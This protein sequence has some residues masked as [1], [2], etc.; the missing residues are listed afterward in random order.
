M[1]LIQPSPLKPSSILYSRRSCALMPSQQCND[2]V[3]R[4]PS[5]DSIN[6]NT[7]HQLTDPNHEFHLKKF[8][9]PGGVGTTPPGNRNFFLI[10][11]QKNRFTLSTTSKKYYQRRYWCPRQPEFSNLKIDYHNYPFIIT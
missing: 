10:F 5:S 3:D 4:K 11:F 9:F 1:F 2:S 7:I 8:R 6:H